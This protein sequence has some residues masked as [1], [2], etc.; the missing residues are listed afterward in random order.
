[1][2]GAVGVKIRVLAGVAAVLVLAG[3]AAPQRATSM[4]ELPP[5]CDCWFKGTLEDRVFFAF[6]TFNLGVDAMAMLNTQGAWLA[7]HPTVK[8]LVAG[9]ADERGTEAYNLAL[10]QRRADAARDDL[11]A[12]GIAPERIKTI[13]Y[14]RTARWCRGMTTPPGSRTVW[15]LHPS[16]V[17]TRRTAADSAAMAVKAGVCVPGVW[18]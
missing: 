1:M 6:D 7:R 9:N 14:G 4:R 3:C 13:S 8:V 2:G 12:Q 5:S 16:S 17:S 10:G 11:I 18:E 15:P